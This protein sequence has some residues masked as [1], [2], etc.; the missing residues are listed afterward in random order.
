[1]CSSDLHPRDV[2]HILPKLNVPIVYTYAYTKNDDYCINYDDFQ[3]AKLAVDHI[4]KKGHKDIAMISGSIDSVP[5][6]KRM[7]GFQT[8]LM[9]HNLI[10]NPK[11]IRPGNWLY[12]D[13]YEQTK[14]LMRLDKPP[15]AIFA[16]ND[17]MAYGA[18]NAS[19]DMGLKISEDIAIHG[20]DNLKLSQYIYPRLSTVDLPLRKM[21]I[22]AARTILEIIDERPPEK[23]S[24]LIDCKHIARQTV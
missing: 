24:I 13:G 2:G 10:F 16:M 23:H 4:I 14:E 19:M 22:R 3:G 17:L 7:M 12:E 15:T 1:M 9:E 6:H 21:G 8:S 5:A 20:F 18:I 11:Y